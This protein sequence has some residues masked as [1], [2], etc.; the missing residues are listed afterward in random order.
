M[1]RDQ[2]L[3]TDQDSGQAMDPALVRASGPVSGLAWDLVLVRVTDPESDPESDQ[4]PETLFCH[5]NKVE[6]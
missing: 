2:D 1:D 5:H 6:K 4:D 3:A